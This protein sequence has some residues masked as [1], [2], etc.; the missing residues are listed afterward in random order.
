[1]AGANERIQH[2]AI[3]LFCGCGGVTEGLKQAGY[4]VVAAVD[5]DPICCETYR[6]NHPE[7]HLI[8]RDICKT[9]AKSLKTILGKRKLDLLVVCAPCQPFSKLN[10]STK[11]DDRVFLILQSIR[12]V[13]ALKPRYVFFENVPGLT[14]N[15]SVISTLKTEFKKL[16]YVLSEPQQVDAAD[17]EVPQRRIRCVIVASRKETI[18]LPVAVT[19]S[20]SR[21]TVRQAIEQLP[22]AQFINDLD[23]LH[24]CRHHS[25]I[26]IRRL[27]HISHDGGSRNE[28]PPDLVLPCHQKLDNDGNAT[29]YC[30]VYGR[31]YWDAVAPTLTTGCTDV[32]K[33]RY[34]HPCYDRAITLREAALLQT[35][36]KTYQFCGNPT[37]I[38]RQIGNAVPVNLAKN[39][40]SVFFKDGGKNT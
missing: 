8:E 30:D 23:P 2:I 38:A 34:A 14:K 31:M 7:V 28:L 27:Q 32:T 25:D 15:H 16:G 6:A 11:P 3:D 4:T 21:V 17:Y 29:H 12:F 33:G 39:L 13:R 36:P 19:P 40:V 24:V 1:M 9:T 20:G 22:A 10:K 35:F 37:Q 26:T 5:N 18:S